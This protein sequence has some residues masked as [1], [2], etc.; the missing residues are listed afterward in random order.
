[1]FII[2]KYVTLNIKL[3]YIPNKIFKKNKGKTIKNS[4][5]LISENFLNHL[6]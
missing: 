3:G 6:K 5:L 2:D 4:L 1:M